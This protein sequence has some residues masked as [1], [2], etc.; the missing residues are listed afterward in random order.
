MRQWEKMALPYLFTVLCVCTV[1]ALCDGFDTKSETVGLVRLDYGTAC[2]EEEAR[3][4][5]DVR[6]KV[7]S[8]LRALGLPFS[9]EAAPCG[10]NYGPRH[11]HVAVVNIHESEDAWRK[12]GILQEELGSDVAQLGQSAGHLAWKKWAELRK[13][14]DPSTVQVGESFQNKQ[15]PRSGESTTCFSPN[16][17]FTYHDNNELEAYLLQV[18]NMYP[19]ITRMYTIGQSVNKRDIW[20]FQISKNPDMNEPEPRAKLVANIHGDEVV[21]RECM[22]HLIDYFTS[23]YGLDPSVTN[24]IDNCD[25]YI[26]PC[27]NPDGFD[28]GTRENAHGVNLNR[29]F[30]DRIE[31][32]DNTFTGR[33]PETVAIMNFT[34]NQR[35]TIGGSFHGGDLVANYP[36]DGN[37]EGAS[38]Y[39]ASPDDEFYILAA[40]TYAQTHPTMS[41]S[42]EFPGG[43]TNGADWYVI[44]GGLQDWSYVW[45][46]VMEITFEISYDKWPDEKTLEGYWDANCPAIM[47]YLNLALQKGVW[48]FITDSTTGFPVIAEVHVQNIST[49]VHSDTAGFYQKLLAPNDYQVFVSA[50]G[51]YPSESYKITI[52]E[53]QQQLLE[54]NIS[55]TP[56]PPTISSSTSSFLLPTPFLLSF[57]PFFAVLLTLF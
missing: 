37:S 54:L 5:S 3:S 29:D 41:Q 27:V 45:E 9:I 38:V 35:F 16:V 23:Q 42:I 34:M 10:A 25:L 51:Y 7:V 56:A 33:Q 48:G 55:L 11:S 19:D 36:Y 4:E 31:D 28:S 47:A 17:T 44:Y 22:I 32:T 21:G 26:L 13:R 53:N 40:S 57:V 18:V 2:L 50:T 24:I 49:S 1:V 52:P 15:K 12:W 20:A 14:K 8:R 43:I 46:E 6:A 39:T 30:P